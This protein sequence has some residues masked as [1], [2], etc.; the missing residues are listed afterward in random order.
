MKLMFSVR[1]FDGIAGGV[2]RM[3]S[4]I[5]N[6]MVKRGHEVHLLTWDSAN[7]QSFF[8]MAAGVNWHK[9]G[10]GDPGAKASPL[11]MFRRALSI[12]QLIRRYRPDVILCFQE[13]QFR[14]VKLYTAGLRQPL[15]AAER[16]APTLFEHTRQGRRRRL[17]ANQS[18][19]FASRI[20]IQC[21]S[22][23][24]LYPSF[25]HDR[26]VTIPNPVFRAS[27]R[28]APQSA[29]IEGRYTL[30]SIGRLEH[31]KNFAALIQAFGRLAWRFP[32]WDLIILGEGEAR[33]DLENQVR[34]E[35][36]QDRVLLPG[37]VT[38]PDAYYKAAHLFCLPS[39][40]EGFPNALAEALAFGLPGVGFAGCAGVNELIED[41]VTGLLAPGNGGSASLA[42]ALSSLMED[43]HRR[44]IM[45]A[46]AIEAMK[47]YDP[48]KM[49]DLWEQTFR[50]TAGA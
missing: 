12:R 45:G 2:E 43:D 21:E 46:A 31:Q 39:R 20:T 15:I 27:D 5:M 44:S 30:L 6:E 26:I 29:G 23:R 24:A 3:C 37:T 40:W 11:T 9:L 25:L 8:P 13:G 34:A 22:Y 42:I 28:A 32:L 7:A 36:L 4:A 1:A 19:R 33:I 48:K 38:S 17:I 10:I 50:E 35:Q 49:M 14:A 41:G 16:N 18:F 47:V